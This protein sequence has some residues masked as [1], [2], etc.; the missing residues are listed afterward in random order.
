MKFKI[1]F[2]DL[3]RFPEELKNSLREK[4][5]EMLDKGL[6][7]GGNEVFKFENKLALYQKTP[8]AVAC[9]NGTD[10]LEIALRVLKIGQGDEVIV[11]AISWV[12]TAEAVCLVGAKPIFIDVDLSGLMDISKLDLVITSRT[13]AIIPVHLYGQMVDMPSIMQFVKNK[14]IKVI[15]DAAQAF[16]SH[17]KGRPAG[18]WGDIGC[19]S[20]YPSKNLGALGEAGALISQNPTFET[21]LRAYINHGQLLRDEHFLVGKNARMDSLQASFLNVLFECFEEWQQ[22]RS[23]LAEVYWE[24]LKDMAWLN[25]PRKTLNGTYNFHLF[26]I[27]TAFRNQLKDFLNNAG[28]QSIIHYPTPIPKMKPYFDSITYPNAE[29][30]CNEIL[31]LPLN[32]WLTENEVNYIC[33][34]IKKFNPNLSS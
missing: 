29:R 25:L 16:G 13:K 11:P 2:L 9:A 8:F 14:P 24:S 33:E 31:S 20:F 5:S 15:E 10:A 32:P 17:L 23:Y 6:F 28:I 1:P 22:N 21:E 3:A 12:S 7:S 26:T 4:F 18:T 27:Q 30:I 34:V 19:L